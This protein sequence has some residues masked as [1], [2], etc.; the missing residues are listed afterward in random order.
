MANNPLNDFPEVIVSALR[1]IELFNISQ[2]KTS[3]ENGLYRVEIKGKVVKPENL[4][5][6]RPDDEAKWPIGT[7]SQYL[8]YYDQNDQ[9]VV[10]M[11]RYLRP[12]G[13]IGASGK[14]EP[15]RILVDGIWYIYKPPKKP[16]AAR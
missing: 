4:P 11:H 15:K 14:A 13:S 7:E 1:V 9:W 5:R 2:H 6:E 3:I 8:F 12:N 10:G 16:P